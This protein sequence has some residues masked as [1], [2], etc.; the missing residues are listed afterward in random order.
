MKRAAI[1]WFVAIVGVCIAMDTIPRERF[2]VP[3][4]QDWLHRQLDRLGLS[5]GSWPLFAPNPVLNNGLV[6]A[7]VTDR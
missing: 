2:P 1:R 5:Q 3:G 7:E 6:V 4:F